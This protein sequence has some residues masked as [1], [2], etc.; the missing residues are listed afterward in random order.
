MM[1]SSANKYK[2][3]WPVVAPDNH[4]VP[5]LSSLPRASS[6]LKAVKKDRRRATLSSGA[7]RI[8]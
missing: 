2:N 5:I 6:E 7:Y 4:H 1:H 8:V 3:A